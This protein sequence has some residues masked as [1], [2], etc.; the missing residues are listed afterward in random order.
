MYWAAASPPCQTHIDTQQ[1]A[2]ETEPSCQK[3]TL[4]NVI[5]VKAVEASKNIISLN[6]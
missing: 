4:I 6:L 5:A 3:T 1:A 2:V